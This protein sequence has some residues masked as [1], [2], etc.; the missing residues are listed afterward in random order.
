MDH[1][2]YGQLRKITL[3]LR[4]TQA[5]NGGND[6]DEDQAYRWALQLCALRCLE[7][8]G[9]VER[10]LLLRG[11][12][13]DQTQSGPARSREPDQLSQGLEAVARFLPSLVAEGESWPSASVPPSWLPVLGG[14]DEELFG[15]AELLGWFHQLWHDGDRE[16]LFQRVLATGEAKIEDGDVVPATRLYTPT[17]IAQFLVANSLG[18]TWAAMHPEKPPDNPYW[19][20]RAR[21]EQVPT[22]PLEQLT[23]LDPACGTGHLLLAAFDQL[24]DLYR[25]AGWTDPAAICQA[26]GRHNLFGLDIDSQAVALAQANLWLRA[27]EKAPDLRPFTFNLATFDQLTDKLH[28]PIIGSLAAATDEASNQAVDAQSPTALTWLN[29]QY[30]IVVCNPPY[31]SNRQ[32]GGVLRRHVRRHFPSTTADLYACFLARIEELTLPGGYFAVVTPLGWTTLP[33][34]ARYRQG[35]LRR[36]QLKCLISL[37]QRTFPSAE[38][39]YVGLTAAQKNPAGQP[40]Q[41][42][43]EASRVTAIRLDGLRPDARW[44]R[45]ADLCQGGAPRSPE[46]VTEVPTGLFRDTPGAAIVP[47]I[48]AALLQ[49]LSDPQGTLSAQA[50]VGAGMDTGENNRF[51]RYRWEVTGL[52]EQRWRPYSKG[53]GFC[54]WVGFQATV[55]DWRD[56]GN[57]IRAQA[58]ATIRNSKHHFQKGLEYSYVFGGKVSCRIL[59]PALLDH[60]SGGIFPFCPA[61]AGVVLSVL[62]SRLATAVGRALSPSI[63]LPISCM[64]R[65]PLPT[66][67]NA[68]RH[69]LN[70][71]ARSCCAVKDWLVH[72]ALAPDW[73]AALP[74]EWAPS[75]VPQPELARGVAAL[76]HLLE[77]ANETG[78]AQSFALSPEEQQMVE[79]ETGPAPGNLPLWTGY[80]R[81]PPQPAEDELSQAWERAAEV[82][83]SCPRIHPT[84]LDE[85]RCIAE[86]HLAAARSRSRPPRPR[87][88]DNATGYHNNGFPPETEVEELASQL[89][90]NPIS[91]HW[92]LT[93]LERRGEAQPSQEHLAALLSGLVVELV[94]EATEKKASPSAVEGGVMLRP[95]EPGA[96]P[97]ADLL[98]RLAT[99][100]WA[101]DGADQ[102]ERWL[103][104]PLDRWLERDF[105][106]IHIRRFKKRPVIWHMQSTPRDR[107]RPA[108]ISCLVSFQCLTEQ[109]LPDLLHKQVIPLARRLRD[110]QSQRDQSEPS[111]VNRRLTNELAEVDQFRRRLEEVIAQGFSCPAA[112]R[113]R[114]QPDR[115]EGV[116]VNVAPLQRAGLLARNV[117]SAK[118]VDRALGDRARWRAGVEP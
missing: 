89:G 45:L 108:A 6:Q 43:Q 88:I 86:N 31:L 20:R 41:Q 37:G 10:D 24:Y 13:W 64:E 87:P 29:R 17:P 19:I 94:R 102:L 101:G 96:S 71:L 26:I 93:E 12:A 113:E 9:L 65:M 22:K 7:V 35:W 2:A 84:N 76:L 32:M 75:R 63:N 52:D 8:R 4:R 5:G 81:L 47:F 105:F 110:E 111:S 36:N 44:R 18:T 21:P 107:R 33:S 30:D 83:A 115:N 70:G 79:Q 91:V 61:E 25:R 23:L 82:L 58:G 95:L 1:Q 42:E 85:A 55:V 106:G 69:D 59:P 114:Y 54:R 98:R 68:R 34:F 50:D 16:E 112:P 99:S 48:P 56:A 49:K 97:S 28:G 103:G 57:L 104:R 100:D 72:S 62:N 46:Q 74:V 14:A 116:R 73:A 53:K 38:L 40:H 90:I 66:A 11:T 39:L 51:V 80:D 60:G 77:G 3:E 109:T 27:V 78:V 118:D 117:L 67:E 92:L 15:H